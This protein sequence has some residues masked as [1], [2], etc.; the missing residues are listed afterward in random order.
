MFLAEPV[1]TDGLITTSS[2]RG[3]RGRLFSKIDRSL[4]AGVD[5]AQEI[6]KA[7]LLD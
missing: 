7:T 4:L 5:K 3:Y 6:A 2:G 1:V